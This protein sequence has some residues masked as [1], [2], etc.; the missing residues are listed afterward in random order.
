MKRFAFYVKL[1]PDFKKVDGVNLEELLHQLYSNYS[2]DDIIII[3]RSN[4]RA[5]LFNQEI[6]NRILF[7]E[8]LINGGD[9]IMAVKNN[10]FYLSEDHELGLIANVEM[11][12]VQRWLEPK[13]MH[14][15]QFAD[16]M[17]QLCDY[18]TFPF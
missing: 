5:N 4:W 3:T 9:L 6:R 10:Y 12:E 2:V 1:T 15:F 8:S 7:R 13:K 18:P 14:G 17:V 11:R 16:L